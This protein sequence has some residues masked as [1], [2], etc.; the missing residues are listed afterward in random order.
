ML[1][2]L[3]A[4]ADAFGAARER[5][6]RSAAADGDAGLHERV[7]EVLEERVEDLLGNGLLPRKAER[8]RQF[9]GDAH[10]NLSGMALACAVPFVADGDG[11]LHDLTGAAIDIKLAAREPTEVRGVGGVEQKQRRIAI[12]RHQIHLDTALVVAHSA[13]KASL[14]RHFSDRL[15]FNLE[16]DQLMATSL[17]N[18]HAPVF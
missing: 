11:R 12:E 3:V 14:A 7:Q 6:D 2:K 18:L 5:L 8:Y 15:G 13:F 1:P 16:E 9:L 17:Q 4:G 10:A